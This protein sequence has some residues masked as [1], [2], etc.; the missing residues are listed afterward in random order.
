LRRSD[1][2]ES[3]SGISKNTDDRFKRRPTGRLFAKWRARVARV[4]MCAHIS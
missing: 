2:E 4:V 1:Q 3:K